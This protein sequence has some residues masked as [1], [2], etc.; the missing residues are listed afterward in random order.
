MHLIQSELQNWETKVEWE[1][2]SFSTQIF[3][4]VENN[5]MTKLDAIVL[6]SKYKLLPIYPWIKLPEFAEDFDYF[7]KYS[8]IDYVDILREKN[9]AP[10][11]KWACRFPEITMD[12]AIDQV[13]NIVKDEGVIGCIFDW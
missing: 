6:I 12:E 9:F 10:Q 3:S 4:L 1:K 2:T 11:D 7:D 13:W 8:T 5:E